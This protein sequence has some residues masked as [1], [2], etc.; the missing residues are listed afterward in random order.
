MLGVDE[1][2]A[3]FVTLSEP[4]PGLFGRLRGEARVR[5]RVM[6]TTPPPKRNRSRRPPQRRGSR[7]PTLGAGRRAGG[8][9]AVK[10][11]AVE[12]SR[13]G[14]A[15]ETDTESARTDGSASG[16]GAG[17][18]RSSRRRR[19]PSGG[20]G[21]GASIAGNGSERENGSE[22]G[23]KAM[24]EHRIEMVLLEGLPRA[25]LNAAGSGDKRLQ[26][27]SQRRRP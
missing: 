1:S 25:G 27:R 3:E 11:F 26:I 4:R 6:P 23:M 21:S 24:K 15:G 12:G 19:R 8:N 18:S 7:E 5:A 10:G 20:G 2:D 17:K 9:R 22:G 16:S 14:S 13:T